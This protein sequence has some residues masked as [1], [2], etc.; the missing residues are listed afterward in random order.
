MSTSAWANILDDTRS[1]IEAIVPTYDAPQTWRCNLRGRPEGESGRTRQFV[2]LRW[3]PVPGVQV[4][5]GKE[6]QL[7]RD[8]D[9]EIYYANGPNFED[10]RHL[11]EQDLVKA[12]EPRSAYPSGSDWALKVRKVVRDQIEIPEP[13]NGTI[14]VRVPLRLIWREPTQHI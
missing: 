4:F 8:L 13:V 7:A 12:L 9:L 11:D 10:Q 14:K 5:G 1:L 2:M 3:T 6:D